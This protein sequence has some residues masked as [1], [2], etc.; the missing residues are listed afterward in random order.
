MVTLAP[1]RGTGIIRAAS[2]G[3]ITTIEDNVVERRAASAR[4]TRRVAGVVAHAKFSGRVSTY[5]GDTMRP[6]TASSTVV[7][8]GDSENP[9]VQDAPVHKAGHDP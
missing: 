6:V 9:V 4:Q 2:S 3:R 7:A 1:M 8:K 5:H